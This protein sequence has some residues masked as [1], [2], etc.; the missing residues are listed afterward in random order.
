MLRSIRL[1]A[2]WFNAIKLSDCYEHYADDTTFVKLKYHTLTIGLI[3]SKRQRI[4]LRLLHAIAIP[5]VVCLSS[6]CCL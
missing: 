3:F 5:S 6:V 4:T 1:I 2:L